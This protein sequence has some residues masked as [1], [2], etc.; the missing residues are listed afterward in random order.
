MYTRIHQSEL[1]IQYTIGDVKRVLLK[2]L[3]IV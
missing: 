2:I 1:H 3:G